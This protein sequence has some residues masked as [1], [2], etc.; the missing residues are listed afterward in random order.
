MPLPHGAFT[1][2]WD[3]AMINRRSHPWISR[4]RKL[5]MLISPYTRRDRRDLMHLLHYDQY[6]HIHLDWNTVD[7]WINEP[8]TPIFLA[9]EGK[10]AVGV[11]A[12]SL[13]LGGASWI[14]LIALRPDLNAD[15]ILAA[16]WAS[17][18]ARL[19]ELGT[20]EMAVLVLR[21]WVAACAEKLGFA[22]GNTIVT[23][24]REGNTVPPALRSDVQIL[25]GN[26]RET[27][28]VVDIDHAAFAPV[29]RLNEASLRQAARSSASFTLAELDG[30]MVAYQISM[31]YTQD[32][33]LSRLATIPEQ[34]GQGI[35]A[36]LL[37]AVIEQFARRGV[38]SMTVN[39][40]QSNVQ[41]LALYHRYGFQA[42][43][44]NMDVWFCQIG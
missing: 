31:L 21:P 13:P 32:A 1:P 14:R 10:Q 43:G 7:E 15:E 3:R 23:L 28:A 20:G 30:Q 6:L 41:S 9:W 38:D 39:T 8:N 37:T 12:A 42:T 40:Q 2:V 17:L 19:L 5:P 16:L 26:W 25:M 35:A 24:R 11:M 4:L 18:K 44:L 29:W 33:H 36:T 27:P 34:Q 22:Q